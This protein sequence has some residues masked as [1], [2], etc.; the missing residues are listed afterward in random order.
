MKMQV[1]SSLTKIGLTKQSPAEIVLT[2]FLPD[3]KPHASIVGI[4]AIGG[5][6]V[7]LRIFTNTRT[8]RNILQSQAAVINIVRDVNLLA[9]LALKGFPHFGKIALKFQKS[10]HVNAP[11]LAKTD[12]RVEIEVEK[13]ERAKIS[14]EIGSSEVAYVTARVKNID[15]I[16][17]SIH[18]FK[19]S[20]FFVIES[21]ILA[22]RIKEALR[23]GRNEVAKKK[24][25]ELCE[26][27]ERCRRIAPDS[28][29]LNLMIKMKDLFKNEMG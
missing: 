19:R 5:S 28:E 13:V 1:M 20:E 4:R 21:A 3:K 16:N 17:P 6:R 7:L 15:V 8:F 18:P 12:A 9:S 10:G 26:Y 27:V 22:T 11:R 2:T 29:E 25:L 24:F 14:D 23:N